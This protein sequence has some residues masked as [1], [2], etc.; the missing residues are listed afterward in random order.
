VKSS[1]IFRAYLHPADLGYQPDE[2]PLIAT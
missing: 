1:L 2:Q